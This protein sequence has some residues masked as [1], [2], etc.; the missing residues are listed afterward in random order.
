MLFQ[1]P[2]RRHVSEVVSEQIAVAN[3]VSAICGPLPNARRRLTCHLQ[4]KTGK[5]VESYARLFCRVG[6]AQAGTSADWPPAL[7]DNGT[8]GPPL[9]HDDIEHRCC[10]DPRKA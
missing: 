3:T 5:D 6:V 4:T 7:W 8:T 9:P 1:A 2:P 10:N